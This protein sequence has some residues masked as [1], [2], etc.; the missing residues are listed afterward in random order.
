M[1]VF[2]SLGTRARK[3]QQ[4]APGGSSNHLK[5]KDRDAPGSLL[6]LR[7]EAFGKQKDGKAAQR[8]MFRTSCTSPSCPAAAIKADLA[9]LLDQGC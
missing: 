6:M 3:Q 1:L 5:R 2:S 4:T 8:P 7:K 9:T